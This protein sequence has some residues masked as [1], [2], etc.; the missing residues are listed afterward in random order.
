MIFCLGNTSLEGGLQRTKGKGVYHCDFNL[1]QNEF[2]SLYID[3]ARDNHMLLKVN[4]SKLLHKQRERGA[5]SLEGE[6]GAKSTHN[7]AA[8]G[9]ESSNN[10]L[11]KHTQRRSS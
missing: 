8:E 2:S 3:S 11:K 7:A 4:K 9:F 5:S 6:G 10:D 1:I